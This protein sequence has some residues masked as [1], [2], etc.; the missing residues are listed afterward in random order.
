MKPVLPHAL[1]QLAASGHCWISCGHL[2]QLSR[3]WSAEVPD[4]GFGTNV[5]NEKVS[6]PES[7]EPNIGLSNGIHGNRI[8]VQGG[9]LVSRVRKLVSRLRFTKVPKSRVAKVVYVPS[10]TQVGVFSI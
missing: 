4:P 5:P 6:W 1:S 9:I 8:S 3:N 2:R 10:V 7:S